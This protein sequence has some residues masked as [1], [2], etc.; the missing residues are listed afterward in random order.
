MSDERPE[1]RTDK[2]ALLEALGLPATP[3]RGSESD[4]E[5]LLDYLEGKLDEERERSLQERL[6]ADPGLSRQLLDLEAFLRAP[7]P[8]PASVADL[9]TAAGW[10][11]FQ[12]RLEA[13]PGRRWGPRWLQTAAGLLLVSNF[14][15]LGLHLKQSPS[16]LPLVAELQT[17]DLDPTLRSSAVEEVLIRPGDPI[18]L[19]LWPETLC[20]AYQLRFEGSGAP[21][22]I[23]GLSRS[24][25]GSLDLW[26]RLEPGEYQV[27]V[28]GCE[29]SEVLLKMPF[30]VLDATKAAAEGAPPPP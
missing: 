7:E 2:E 19:V 30:R 22:P 29:S 24:P 5:Q 6:L 9:P 13:R 23:T 26:A 8:G 21:P 16:A 17:L 14:A 11:D 3:P 10:R 1:E 20:A 25:Q 15:L 12:R 27:R 18:R 28:T 4:T